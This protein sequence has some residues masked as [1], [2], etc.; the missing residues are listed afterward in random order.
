MSRIPE[1][2]GSLTLV[3]QLGS[4]RHCQVWEAIDTATG[5]RVA[6]KVVVPEMA[7]DAGQ[8]RLLRHER[9]VAAALDHPSLLRIGDFSEAGGLPHLVMELFPHANLKRQIA[10]GTD[11]IAPRLHRIVTQVA[12]ALDHM[13]GRGWVHR[14]VKP[15]NVLA[16]ADGEAKLIDFAIA[17]RRPGFIGRVWPGRRPVQGTPSY[18]SPEQIRGLPADPR[19][20]I[21][22]LGCTLHYLLTGK[23]PFSAG[24]LGERIRAH[25]STPPPNLLEARADVPP[26]LAELYF[27]MMEKHPEARPQTAKEVADALDA[28][29][30]SSAAKPGDPP[31]PPRRAPPRRTPA[32]GSDV[33]RILPP[34]T[35]MRSG[36]SSS[37]G[38]VV[39]PG[40]SGALGPGRPAVKPA[41]SSPAAAPRAQEAID[42][43]QLSFDQP[44]P[45]AGAPAA[46]PPAAQ[47]TSAPHVPHRRS[48]GAQFKVRLQ[49]FMNRQVAGLPMGF[50]IVVGAAA[51]AVIG[52]LAGLAFGG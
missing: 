19:S 25:K 48:P 32:P 35:V 42:L 34:G 36:P 28:W 14:D 51:L 29:L 16:A 6:V 26:V 44:A 43:S 33:K 17:A 15:D 52:L 47:P 31:E 3:R 9:A 4:G 2:L 18:I 40:G 38:R 12:W 8:R 21:Y 10:A 11:T 1:Q 30:A 5:G 27:R 24:K 39:R 22:S 37:A 13:H 23:P 49:E 7:R 50:W 41:S 45:G 20:D 46:R